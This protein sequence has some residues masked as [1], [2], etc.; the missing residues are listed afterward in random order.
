MT[1]LLIGWWFSFGP[2]ALGGPATFAIVDGR[3]MEPTYQYGDLVVARTKDA[4]AV[5]DVVVFPAT[6]KRVI[7][8]RIVAGNAVDGWTTRGDNNDRDDSWV[9]PDESILGEE[10]FDVPEVGHALLWTQRHPWQ[11]SG[12]VGVVVLGLSAV[13]SRTRRLHPLMSGAMRRGRRVSPMA[14]RNV[15]EMLLAVTAALAAVSALVSLTLLWSVDMIL[16]PAAA[17]AAVILT[18]SALLVRSLARRLVDGHGLGEPHSSRVVLS[19]RCWAV[20]RLPALAAYRDYDSAHDLRSFLQTSNLPVLR[21]GNDDGTDTF[22]AI[23]SDKVGHRWRTRWPA[24]DPT[25]AVALAPP[26]ATRADTT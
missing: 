4:Y 26:P 19:E 14:G 6:N 2:V 13:S 10:W 12:T 18:G 3:S 17:V 1:G 11:F 5:G 7:I 20:E 9:L 16:S 15:A 23:D 8:H 21:H 25:T 22:L 24:P